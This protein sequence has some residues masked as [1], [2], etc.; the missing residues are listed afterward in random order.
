LLPIETQAARD[1][2]AAAMARRPGVEAGSVWIGTDEAYAKAA[3]RAER[4]RQLIQ[5]WSRC[6]AHLLVIL[7]WRVQKR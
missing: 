6:S 3:P 5:F 1:V 7:R 2:S 4:V